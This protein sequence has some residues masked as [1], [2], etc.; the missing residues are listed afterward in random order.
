M[1]T[2]KKTTKTA[3]STT[4]TKKTAAAATPKKSAARADGPKKAK[5]TATAQRAAKSAKATPAKQTA[6]HIDWASAIKKAAAEKRT[7]T[8]WPG[9]NDAWKKQGRS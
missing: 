3:K 5:S 7:H 2:A 8:Y 9:H 6:A 4:A 1:P